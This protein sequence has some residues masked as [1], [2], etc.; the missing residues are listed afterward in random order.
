MDVKHHFVIK[1]KSDEE[2]IRLSDMIL[3]LIHSQELGNFE[4]EEII[5]Y[6]YE[7]NYI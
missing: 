2:R 6:F 1:Y 4:I 5:F 7:Q 3:K